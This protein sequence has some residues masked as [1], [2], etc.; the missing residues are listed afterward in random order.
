MFERLFAS[1]KKPFVPNRDK[2][3]TLSA[4]LSGN[5]LS[6][7]LPPNSVP[8]IDDQYYG[9]RIDIYNRDAYDDLSRGKWYQE[10]RMPGQ[11]IIKRNWGF[12]G[13]PWISTEYGLLTLSIRVY[14]VDD[15]PESMTCFNPSHLEQVILRNL[16]FQYGPANINAWPRLT[17]VNWQEK[18]INGTD[19]LYCEAYRK[20]SDAE[21]LA[22]PFNEAMYSSQ[23]YAPLDDQYFIDI[24]FNAIGYAPANYSISAMNHLMSDI[25]ST[26]SLELSPAMQQR[27]R[28]VLQQHPDS[29]F[30]ETRNPEPWVYHEFRENDEENGEDPFVIV[31]KGTPPP[32]FTPQ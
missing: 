23:L 16:Y 31:K 30:S 9:P 4:N 2:L 6:I 21:I 26:L 29:K 7:S 3:E 10:G 17:P 18:T 14:R 22:N 1:R 5:R 25:Y 24:Y 15:L 8:E 28:E 20:C 13:P 19:W 32:S 12:Y 11:S 27:R